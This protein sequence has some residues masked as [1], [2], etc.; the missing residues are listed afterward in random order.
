MTFT[1]SIDHAPVVVLALLIDALVGDPARV[2]RRIPHP[3]VIMGAA[4]AWCEE[5]WNDPLLGDRTRR[6]RGVPVIVLLVAVSASAGWLIEV[7]VLQVPGGYLLEAVLAA[8]LLAQRSLYRHVA[9]VAHALEGDG[10][11]AA[12]N[13][14]SH[15]VGRTP[16]QLDEPGVARAATESLAENFADAV[17]APVFWFMVLGLPGMVACKMINTADSMIGHRSERYRAFGWAAARLDDL[18]NLVPARLGAM[19]LACA[20]VTVGGASV[21]SALRAVWRDA[22]RHRSVNAGWPEAAMAGALGFRL[23]GPRAY[24]GVRIDDAWMGDG[25][26]D[27]AAS[28]IRRA[29]R[30]F[31]SAC[32]LTGVPAAVLYACHIA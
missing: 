6:M 9:D 19:F 17:V 16:G 27:L 28:D 5:K 1:P 23:A 7:L 22:R 25:R 21:R 30:L 18:M 2:W 8:T 32:V 11:D 24:D 31:R 26:A 14:V 10:L 20:A 12:R 4:V 13:A 29:L 3:V 15:I